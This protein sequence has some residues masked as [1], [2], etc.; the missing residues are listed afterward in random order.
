MVDR[1]SKVASPCDE[2][3]ALLEETPSLICYGGFL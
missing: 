1:N 2:G 3:I